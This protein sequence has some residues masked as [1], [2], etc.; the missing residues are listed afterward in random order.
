MEE[1]FIQIF[2]THIA[3]LLDTNQFTFEDMRFMILEFTK[4]AEQIH[5]RGDLI[6]FLQ[7]YP[8][9]P[10]LLTLIKQLQDPHYAFV[11]ME[12]PDSGEAEA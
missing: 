10:E 5:S 4:V 7:Q 3:H 2:C 12:L 9:H 11:P 6:N 8:D 1:N